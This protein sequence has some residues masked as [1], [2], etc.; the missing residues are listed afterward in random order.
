MGVAIEVPGVDYSNSGLPNLWWVENYI[1]GKS[2]STGQKAALRAFYSSFAANSLDKKFS[3]LYFLVTTDAGVDRINL[4]K[5][6]DQLDDYSATFVNDTGSA[7]TE[8]GFRPDA[9]AGRYIAS[10]FYVESAS[11][12]NNFH[13]HVYNRNAQNSGSFLTGA[14]GSGGGD[15]LFISISRNSASRTAGGVSIN[16]VTSTPLMAEVGYDVTKIGIISI[17]RNGSTQKMFDGGVQIASASISPAITVV[18]PIRMY[19]GTAGLYS[20]SWITASTD[21]ALCAW[22]A[23]DTAIGDSE[24]I[25]FH[26]MVSQLI[27]A[28]D[29]A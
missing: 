29:A 5:P 25:A 21:I 28:W 9:T 6:I 26:A 8:Q 19:V 7:H 4:L 27:T 20:S 18:S 1:N 2:F 16:G 10:D 3:V 11:Q 24:T 23:P 15:N 12:I 17:T 14:W 13:L 22:G